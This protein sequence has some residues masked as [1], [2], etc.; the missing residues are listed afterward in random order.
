MMNQQVFIP[1]LA[2]ICPPPHFLLTNRHGLAA[3][4]SAR[5]LAPLVVRTLRQVGNGDEV[6]PHIVQGGEQLELW[7][8]K[9]AFYHDHN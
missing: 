9:S 3:T 2:R 5:S 7:K 8:G 4:S 1:K 6:G